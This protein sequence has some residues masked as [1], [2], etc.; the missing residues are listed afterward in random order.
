MMIQHIDELFVHDGAEFVFRAYQVLLD[1]EPDPHGL[2]FYLGRMA[3]GYDKSEII[4]NLATSPEAKNALDIPGV[5]HLIKE[6][7]RNRHWL[8]G[9]LS[10]HQRIERAL[11]QLTQTSARSQ[12][13]LQKL[14]DALNS[15]QKAFEQC[16][17]QTL[18][19]STATGP[20]TVVQRL[21]ADEVRQAFEAVLGR[22]PESDDVIAHHANFASPQH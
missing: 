18:R 15:A 4:V 7:R 13:A 22:Q 21:S 8:W 20:V 17:G 5:R 2:D 1:R 6:Y 9:W 3:R 11:R 12:H 10:R 16:A 14:P 19:Q